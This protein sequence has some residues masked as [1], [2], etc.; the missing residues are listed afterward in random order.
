M[1]NIENTSDKLTNKISYILF[2]AFL[3]IISNSCYSKQQ[4]NNSIP[5]NNTTQQKQV[6][7]RI[8]ETLKNHSLSYDIDERSIDVN[9]STTTSI[10]VGYDDLE[11][12]I[13]EFVKNNLPIKIRMIGF[14]FK[15]TNIEQKVISNSPDMAERHSLEYLQSILKQ[16]NDIYPK[17]V[18]L[19]LICDG[20]AFSDLLGIPDET[21]VEYEQSL[22]RLASDLSYIS[23][24]CHKD[25][26]KK[27]KSLQEIRDIIDS[28][29][30]NDEEFDKKIKEDKKISSELDIYNKRIAKELNHSKGKELKNSKDQSISEISKLILKRSLRF[31]SLIKE[32]YANEKMIHASVHYQ[33]NAGKKIGIK[34]SETSF[35]TP[36]HGVFVVSKDGSS[37]IMHK[38]DINLNNY[39]QVGKLVNGYMCLYYQE[40][41]KN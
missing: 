25:I 5:I 19:I 2:V 7:K 11:K 36:W 22:K 31:G 3:I 4:N 41:A 13:L 23:I 34:L 27:A 21:I 20:S 38:E 35:I 9:A 18:Q 30:P 33:K 39:R 14:P 28:Y 12:Q 32:K 17:G 6:A 10:V 37:K 15:S 26:V 8:C 24:A 1:N 29:P 40:F 16:L